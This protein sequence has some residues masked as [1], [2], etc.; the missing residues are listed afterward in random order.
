MAATR[1]KDSNARF[2]GFSGC[3]AASG[4]FTRALL[5]AWLA[6]GL[7]VVEP[8]LASSFDDGKLVFG[9]PEG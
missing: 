4:E 2:P 7:D 8:A 1:C 9:V 3:S 5:V 6:E